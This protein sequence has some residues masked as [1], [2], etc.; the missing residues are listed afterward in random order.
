MAEFAA[1]NRRALTGRR[2]TLVTPEGVDLSLSLGEFGQRAGAF[3]IDLIVM[4]LILV[5]F[6]LLVLTF[7]SSIGAQGFEIAAVIWLLGFFLLRNFYFIVMEMGP[8]AATWG[9]RAVGLRVIARSGE[10]LIAD[11]VVARNLMRE[12]EFYLPLSFLGYNAAEGSGSGL[13]ALAGLAW[14]AIFIFFPLFNQDRLRVGDLLAGTWVVNVPKRKLSVDRLQAERPQESFSF[15]DAQLDVYGIY[16]LQTLEQVL[17]DD[18]AETIATVAATIRHKI[19]TTMLGADRDFL[20][21]YYDAA[22]AKM[23][24]GLLFGK[25]REDKFDRT[26][27]RLKGPG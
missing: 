8:R 15:T 12:I 9:K 25:R 14:T 16:E 7:I 13:V 26:A 3:L 4:V 21:A 2:R 19:E 11:R 1:V 5:G 24:R 27:L 10:R 22:R 6:S 23:E 17:R 20:I 18:N